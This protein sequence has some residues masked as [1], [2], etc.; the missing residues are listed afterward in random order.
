MMMTISRKYSADLQKEWDVCGD[1]AVK[2][3]VC[4]KSITNS[5]YGYKFGNEVTIKRHL[6]LIS[7]SEVSF[8]YESGI[9]KLLERWQKIVE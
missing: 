8:S 1:N 2:E 9:R 5:L 7:Y 4:Q 3:C 6:E